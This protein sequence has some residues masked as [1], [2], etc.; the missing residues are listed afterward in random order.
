MAS[1]LNHRSLATWLFVE[2]LVQAYIKQKHPSF[3]L[4]ALCDGKPPING[5][6][7]L[8]LSQMG[9]DELTLDMLDLFSIVLNRSAYVVSNAL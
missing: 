1:L 7:K 9:S 6:L 3:A 8:F 2:Q 4:R 5:G